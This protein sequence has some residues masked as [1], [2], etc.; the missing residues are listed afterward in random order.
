MTRGSQ[1]PISL[2]SEHPIYQE[3]KLMIQTAKSKFQLAHNRAVQTVLYTDD[4][5]IIAK[6]KD[7]FQVATHQLNKSVCK[8]DMNVFILKTKVIGQRE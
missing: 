3:N 8:Y 5:I 7:K 2:R 1:C 4:L 6:C